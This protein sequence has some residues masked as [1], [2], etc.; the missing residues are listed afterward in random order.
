MLY[1]T[2]TTIFLCLSSTLLAS[3]AP[4]RVVP[5]A[6]SKTSSASTSTPT[7][8]TENGTGD[9]GPG[10]VVFP[11]SVNDDGT[12]F[13]I[14]SHSEFK[15][16][17][18]DV[19]QVDGAAAL[20]AKY[21]KGSYAG[22]K[23]TPGI[24]GFIFDTN[25][26]TDLSNAKEAI[27]NYEVKFPSGFD[28]VLAGKIPGLYGGDNAKVGGTCAGGHHN[29]ECW[30]ARLMWREKGKGELYAYLPTANQ[31]LAVCKGKCDVHYGAS[32]GTGSWTFQ[33]GKWTKLTER[34]LLNDNG[35]P[36]GEIEVSVDGKQVILVDK[37]TL[38][39][40]EQGRIQGIMVHTF[41]GGSS[42]PSYQSPKDQEAYFRNFNL[43]VSKTL[44]S[45]SGGG[46]K[47]T[48]NDKK[49]SD[50]VKAKL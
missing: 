3:A 18:S 14:K 50:P 48:G 31:K 6:K 35:Q 16:K 17:T 1:S 47:P 36:N 43:K 34:V 46:T 38:R 12:A 29:D 27:L 24:A 9:Q 41:F 25:G 15:K 11:A 28:F 2:A 10:G 7:G 21:P 20:V 23:G 22:S 40:S 33:P 37:L 42:T 44:D 5:R 19:Q 13:G 49:K 4:I 45:T 39:T 30:S 8:G 32:I 26:G